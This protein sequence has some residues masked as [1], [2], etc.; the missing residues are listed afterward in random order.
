MSLYSTHTVTRKHAINRIKSIQHAVLNRDHQNLD[1]SCFEADYTV[2]SFVNEH[3]L[4][5]ISDIDTWTNDTIQEL[6][7]QPFYRETMFDNYIIE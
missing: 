7:N 1:K 2:Y 6:L 4:P 5:D 3:I